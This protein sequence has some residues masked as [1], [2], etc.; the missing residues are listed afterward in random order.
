MHNNMK[1]RGGSLR[2]NG[3]EHHEVGSGPGAAV[4]RAG[5]EGMVCIHLHS[6]WANKVQLRWTQRRRSKSSV[7]R[8]VTHARATFARGC[9]SI[10]AKS[11]CS[12]SRLCVR[13]GFRPCARACSK[14]R[15]SAAM[16][17]TAISS[18]SRDPLNAFLSCPMFLDLRSS[19]TALSLK[20]P[21]ADSARPMW[22]APPHVG[23]V[24]VY[25]IKNSV[26]MPMPI[27]EIFITIIS[28]VKFSAKRHIPTQ[29]RFPAPF[30][31]SAK[32]IFLS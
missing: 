4:L 19:V 1:T 18:L 11:P 17:A 28:R 8:A 10:S 2:P 14:A 31:T 22:A 32:V 24:I 16:R 25:D 13:C 30:A 23:Q 29:R 9:S 26:F 3:Q 5:A 7:L 27:D 21:S 20:V 15:S 6:L 12:P